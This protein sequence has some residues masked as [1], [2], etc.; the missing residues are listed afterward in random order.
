[1]P[2]RQEFA[3]NRE[4]SVGNQGACLPGLRVFDVLRFIQDDA[5]LGKGLEGL[6]VSMQERVARD[7]HGMA[8]G[9]L[10]QDV[11]LYLWYH[12]APVSSGQEA[13][14]MELSK[15]IKAALELPNGARFYRCAFQVNPW[16][17]G[18]SF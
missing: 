18:N 1:V 17:F 8:S 10:L 2:Q 9:G 16:R 11:I 3:F 5:G 7:D 4:H 14:M 15:A 12:Q 13:D 6:D